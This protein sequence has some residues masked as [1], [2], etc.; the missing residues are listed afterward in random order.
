LIEQLIARRTL[1]RTLI[2]L[3]LV[4]TLTSGKVR[5]QSL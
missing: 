4:I 1:F 5:V 2:S 3:Q